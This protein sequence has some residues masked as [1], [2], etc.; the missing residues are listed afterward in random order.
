VAD[1]RQEILLLGLLKAM[2]ERGSWCGETHVQKCV[3][4]L[5]EGLG[6][7]LGFDFMLYKHGPFSFELREALGQMR[8]ELLIDIASRGPYGP[9][10]VVTESGQGLLSLRQ[11]IPDSHNDK[12]AFVAENLGPKT[13]VELERLGTALYVTKQRPGATP[14]QRASD[15]THA[16]P[17]VRL[18]DSR[19]AVGQ[20]DALLAQAPFR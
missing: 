10:L 15:L 5:Q 12:A 14:E 8:D 9:S 7:P 20:V 11:G 13:V 18:E 1:L 6:V 19:V 16:K 2:E 4:F 3:Y 17:H